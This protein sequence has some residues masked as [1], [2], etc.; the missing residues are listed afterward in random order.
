MSNVSNAN[1]NNPINKIRTREDLEALIQSN[2]ESF[3]QA[4]ETNMELRDKFQQIM[5]HANHNEMVMI[6]SLMQSPPNQMA[7]NLVNQLTI[8]EPQAIM[9]FHWMRENQN[10]YFKNPH[11]HKYDSFV[12]YEKAYKARIEARK[13]LEEKRK[14][15]AE[16]NKVKQI[17]SFNVALSQRMMLQTALSEEIQKRLTE[18]Q[19]YWD[20]AEQYIGKE[21]AQDFEETEQGYNILKE[22]RKNPNLELNSEQAKVAGKALLCEITEQDIERKRKLNDELKTANEQRAVEIRQELNDIKLREELTEQENIKKVSAIVPG[23][24]KLSV[25]EQRE[26]MARMEN[27]DFIYTKN[28][29]AL[30]EDEKY[31]RLVEVNGLDFEKLKDAH[32]ALGG[33]VFSYDSEYQQKIEREKL[34]EKMIDA[35]EVAHENRLEKIEESIDKTVSEITNELNIK[36]EE[37]LTTRIQSAFLKSISADPEMKVHFSG[38]LKMLEMKENGIIEAKSVQTTLE[39]LFQDFYHTENSDPLSNEDD[40]SVLAQKKREFV[41]KILNDSGITNSQHITQLFEQYGEHYKEAEED[42]ILNLVEIDNRIDR[43]FDDKNLIGDSFNIKVNELQAELNKDIEEN[44]LIDS[45]LASI[46]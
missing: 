36:N 28:K 38:V 37:E 9:F 16:E 34:K 15:E 22:V 14:L 18:I 24:E 6:A 45:Y 2:P 43:L 39:N 41:E 33:K 31:K 17:Q 25:D 13:E 1:P 27:W 4:L 20:N 32:Q 40:I 21:L 30:K 7:V 10:A 19:N 8:I 29:N 44:T 23:F 12:E 5:Q 42:F 11:F 46:R 26:I 35:F 3:R